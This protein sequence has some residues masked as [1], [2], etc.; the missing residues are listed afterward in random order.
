MMRHMRHARHRVLIL[1]GSE[2]DL[3][4][5]K[6]SIDALGRFGIE[7]EFHVASAHRTPDR[8]TQFASEARANGFSAVIAGAG[9]AAHL[10]GVLAAFTT[11]PVIGVPIGAGP[12]KGQDALLAIA[13]MPQG[14]PVATVAIDG[15]FNAGLLAARIIGAHDDDVARMLDEYR[16]ELA[17]KVVAADERV[18]AQLAPDTHFDASAGQKR[19]ATDAPPT[20]GTG[21]S[22]P[23]KK[24]PRTPAVAGAPN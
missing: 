9:L 21:L 13:Q 6:G 1:V 17:A 19:R 24:R 2:N 10:P 8:A 3:P 18:Q 12:L 11:L 23:D 20:G 15:A 22:T 14:I 5:M 4:V 7:A 16:D